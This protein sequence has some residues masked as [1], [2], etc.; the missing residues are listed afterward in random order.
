MTQDEVRTVLKKFNYDDEAI[1]EY[2]QL[3]YLKILKNYPFK[4]FNELI[5]IIKKEDID[6]LES[7]ILLSN[8]KVQTIR[9]ITRALKAEHIDVKNNVKI[10]AYSDIRN[11]EKKILLLK[12]K[13]I[14]LSEL[15]SKTLDA[16]FITYHY[17]YLVNLI[18]K[19]NKPKIRTRSINKR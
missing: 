5:K 2:L 15:D 1:N 6:L 18:N 11:V 3:N 12:E 10:L 14:L 17:D 19:T 8:R 9:E 16:I 7:S 4:K 13:G